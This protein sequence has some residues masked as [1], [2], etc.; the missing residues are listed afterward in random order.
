MFDSS[1]GPDWCRY[2][3]A[4]VEVKPFWRHL[5]MMRKPCS[6]WANA[7]LSYGSH[8]LTDAWPHN[9]LHQGAWCLNVND[10]YGCTETAH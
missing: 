5:E 4:D 7:L 8:Y 9:D 6:R 1:Y 10:G 2:W 3:H